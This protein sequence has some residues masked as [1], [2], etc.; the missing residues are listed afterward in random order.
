MRLSRMT[1]YLKQT[2]EFQAVVRSETGKP[3]LNEYGEPSYQEPVVVKCRREKYHVKAATNTGAFINC[4]HTYYLD[5]SVKPMVD[6]MLD[7]HL[8]QDVEEYV[9]GAGILVGYEVSV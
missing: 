7:G 1:R 6:D 3:Q 8:I 4:M 9:D 5:D 2:A